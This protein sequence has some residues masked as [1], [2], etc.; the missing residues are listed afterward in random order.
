MATIHN[1]ENTLTEQR[2]KIKAA[3]TELAMVYG[4][5]HYDALNNVYQRILQ[6]KY[7]SNLP[8]NESRIIFQGTEIIFERNGKDGL[9]FAFIATDKLACLYDRLATQ[10]NAT[11]AKTEE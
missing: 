11:L 8:I 10:I 6:L 1:F 3:L 9:P 7:Y 5:D 2:E 4:E